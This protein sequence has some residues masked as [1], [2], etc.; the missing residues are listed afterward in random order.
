[1]NYHFIIKKLF[2][3]KIK[4]RLPK[5]NKVLIYD[6]IGSELF[7]KFFKREQCEIFHTRLEEINIPILLLSILNQ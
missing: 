5:K 6:E 4:L 3:C 2:K 7:F 1:M